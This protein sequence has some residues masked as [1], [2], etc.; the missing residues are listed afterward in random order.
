MVTP[1]AESTSLPPGLGEGTLTKSR[2][3]LKAGLILTTV[4]DRDGGNTPRWTDL[5]AM[6]RRAEEVGFDSIWIP[7]HLTHKFDGIPEY[8]IW[9]CWSLMCGLAAVTSRV[10]IGS[11]VLCASFR[12]PALLAKMADT[13]DEISNGRLLLALGAGWHEPEYRAF[14]FP[15]DHR[16]GR[17]EESLTII[18]SLLREGRVDFHGRVV[19]ARDCELRPRGPRPEGPP[20]VIGTIAG[21]PLGRL[22]GLPEPAPGESRMLRLVARFADEWN[23]PWINDP[24]DLAPLQRAI[25]AACAAENRDPSTLLRSH[26]VAVNLPFWRDRPGADRVRATRA[27]LNPIEG[28]PDALADSLRRF[29]AAGTD[30]VHVQLDPETI[31]GIDAFADVLAILDQG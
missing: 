31:E 28:S 14:G 3:P 22:L 17:F 12:N 20:I 9:E 18:H 15:F 24:A 10:E 11:W 29:A 13:L 1:S 16:I 23:V 2:R 8:G 27:N 5:A 26:G 6:A 25:E 4:E 7:D 19:E 30:H 21:S